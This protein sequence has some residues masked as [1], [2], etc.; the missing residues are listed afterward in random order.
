[1]KGYNEKLKEKKQKVEEKPSASSSVNGDALTNGAGLLCI[2][3]YSLM[4]H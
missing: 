1:M 2:S 3:C 4:H